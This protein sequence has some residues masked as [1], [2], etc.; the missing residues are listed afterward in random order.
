MPAD[1]TPARTELF[2]VLT[3]G[4]WSLAPGEAESARQLLDNYRTEVL[5]QGAAWLEGD[6]QH[7]AA[8][9]LR[10]TTDKSTAAAGEKGSATLAPTP[11][12]QPE[13]D[14][15]PLRWGLDDVMYGDDDSTTILLSGPD[16]A[17]YW[18]ELGSERT[19]ALRQALAGPEQPTPT[20]DAERRTILRAAIADWQGEWTTARAHHFLQARGISNGQRSQARYDLKA[21]HRDGLL[22]LNDSNPDRV[23][24]TFN[25]WNGSTR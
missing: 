2:E 5:H 10:S 13:A 22:V 9:M 18:L 21:L 1:P 11:T 19:T 7:Y 24:Y 15:V 8:A 16:G 17:P 14:P 12:P 25:S 4:G 3:D 6:G 23:F 20:S